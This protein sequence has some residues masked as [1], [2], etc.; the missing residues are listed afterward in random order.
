MAGTVTGGYRNGYW[1]LPE[2]YKAVGS[3]G[4]LYL[5]GNNYGT[6]GSYVKTVR[7]QLWNG[8]KVIFE[9]MESGTFFL[10]AVLDRQEE[11][12]SRERGKIDRKEREMAGGIAISLSIASVLTGKHVDSKEGV[13]GWIVTQR[14][15]E[16]LRLHQKGSRQNNRVDEL[17]V[18][19]G[20]RVEQVVRGLRWNLNELAKAID[21]I[22]RDNLKESGNRK[23]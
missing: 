5:T 23:N 6:A 19:N 9:R 2:R 4:Y 11:G 15:T 13:Y 21:G 1:R 16:A 7:E 10:Y 18:V 3:L 12:E 20:N 22:L 17:N 8:K 14:S